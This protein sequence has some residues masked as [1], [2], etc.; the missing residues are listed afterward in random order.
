[1]D[2]LPTIELPGLLVYRARYKSVDCDVCEEG[3]DMSAHTAVEVS[4]FIRAHK[5]CQRPMHCDFIS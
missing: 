2:P 5:G 1:M 4:A 3:I